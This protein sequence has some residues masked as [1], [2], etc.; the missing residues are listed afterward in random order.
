MTTTNNDFT[1]G[2]AVRIIARELASGNEYLP[3]AFTFVRRTPQGRFYVKDEA[4]KFLLIRN[5]NSVV[6]A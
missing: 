2:Q 3:G 6:A 5:R 4:G 1:K